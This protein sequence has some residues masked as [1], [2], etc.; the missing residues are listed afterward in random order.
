MRIDAADPTGAKQNGWLTGNQP[1][2][3]MRARQ[4]RS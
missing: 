3:S 1:S 2:A 4:S